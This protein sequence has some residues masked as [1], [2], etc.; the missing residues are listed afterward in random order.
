MRQQRSETWARRATG[1][2]IYESAL[3]NRPFP[4]ITVRRYQ[5]SRLTIPSYII[6]GTHPVSSFRNIPRR[7]KAIDTGYPYLVA[8][9]HAVETIPKEAGAILKLARL[10]TRQSLAESS[11]P[12][13]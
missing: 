9:L 5:P 6:G 3:A 4:I 7:V 2:G 1:R 13:L 11:H 12:Y 10:G 8:L